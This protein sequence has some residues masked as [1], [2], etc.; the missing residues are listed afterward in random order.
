MI[1]TSR[2][3]LKSRTTGWAFGDDAL[4]ATAGITPLE[5]VLPNQPVPLGRKSCALST[6]LAGRSQVI[7]QQTAAIG[8]FC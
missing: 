4:L 6:D 5:K 2:N 3:L 8:G 1:T 7:A